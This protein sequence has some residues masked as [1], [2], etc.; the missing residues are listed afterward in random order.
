MTKTVNSACS[1]CGTGCGIRLE[2]DGQRI[3]SLRGD[4][5]HPTNRGKL[6]S[7]GRELHHTISTHDR[8]LHPQLRTSLNAPFAPVDWDT[9]LDYGADKFAKIIQEHGPDAVAFYVSGQLLTED[10]YVFN[11]LMKGFIGSN[12]IDTNS[13]LCMSSAVVAYKRAFG[14]DGPPTCYEDIELAES[15]FIIGANPAY[16]HPIIFRRMEAAKEA[17]PNLKIIV[18]DPRRT[19]TCSIADLYL[20]LKPGTDVPLMQAML[21]VMIW[22]GLT[23]INYIE[24]YTQGFDAL[25]ERVG[26]MT[27]RK[28]A[29]ICGL[30]AAD[31]VKAALWFAENKTVS[32]WTMGLNQ[33][34]SGTDKN[35]ALINLHLATGQVGKPGC[36]PFSL[37]GQP[38]AMGGREVGGLA[39]MLAAH[40]D[41]TN[42]E[43]RKEVADY[44][45]VNDVPK[46]PGLTAT[47]LF[48]GLESGKVK[49]VWIACTNPIVSMPDS[50][51]VEAALK[52]AE[53]VMVSDAYHPTDTTN[54]AHILFPASGWAEKEGTVTNSER[55]ITHLQQALPAAGLSRNDWKIAADFGIKLGE[56]LDK[57]WHNSFS[58]ESTEAVFNEH[59]GL[60]KGKDIDITGLSYALLDEHGAQQW[61]FPIGS[62]VGETK[63]LYEHGKFE[64]A[65]GLAHFIDVTYRSVAEPTDTTYPM[66]LTTGRI[67]DQWHTMTK[68]GNVPSLMQHVSAPALQIHPDDAG[69]YNIDEDDLVIVRSRRG[70]TITTVNINRDIREGVVFLPMHWGKMTAPSGGANQVTKSVVDPYSKEPEFKHSAVQIEKFEPAWRGMMLMAGNKMALGQEMIQGYTYGVTACAGT[71]HPVTSIELA[72]TKALKYEQ[73][74]RLDQMLEQGQSFETL[75]YSDRKHG[76]HRKAWLDDGH[77]VAVRWVGGDIHEAKW[78]R[79]LMLEGRDVG[80]LRPYLLA[81][82]GPVDKQDTKGKIICACNNVGELEL[83]GAIEAGSDSIEKLKGCTMA[84]TGCG[85]CVPEMKRLLSNK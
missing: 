30:D 80:E 33:S 22:E 61:P 16:A 75:T 4:V 53:L 17:N 42:P 18:A 72:C 84:G 52:K 37:T 55:R 24:Q 54:F 85:S 49:A 82:G 8:L 43:H 38:N 26:A 63:R 56:K 47:E 71:D 34:T 68:T 9:A 7:K 25:A 45:G 46:T 79:K 12:N 48:D 78:L 70:Q 57:D 60:T 5:H 59:R 35:N 66:S 50:K 41:Y 77:L 19:D 15:Y 40:R 6:C 23:D 2:T 64:T 13:R 51:K 62:S 65:D 21:N 44:W 28:A 29:A 31:I 74:K 27:P 83:K 10:Y 14:A 58:F 11:K 73:H 32:F 39:N 20:P 36:G 67:R 69:A 3:I 1:Y 76:I 81:P